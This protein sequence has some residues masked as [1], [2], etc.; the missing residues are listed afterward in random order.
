MS[1]VLVT[2]EKLDRLASIIAG[3][4][5]E[6]VKLTIDG[7]TG[8]AE[9]IKIEPNL[10][11]KSYTVDGAGTES[12]TADSGYDGLSEVEVNIRSGSITGPSS[13]YTS[14]SS[15][16]DTDGYGRLRVTCTD[17][18]TSP[19]VSS[20]GWV[21]SNSI[22][23][24][25]RTVKITTTISVNPT[26]TVSG[27]TVTIPEGYYSSQSTKSVSTM[28]LPTEASTSSYSGS[29]VANIN[30]ITS[31]QYLTIPEGYNGSACH[32]VI[33]AIQSGTQGTPTATKGVVSNHAITVTPSVTN[34][35]GYISGGTLTGTGVS[36]SASE[37]VGGTYTVSSSGTADVT[38]YASVSVP[39]ASVEAISMGDFVTQSGVLK[40]KLNAGAYAEG[41]GW[42]DEGAI[43]EDI[44]YFNAVPANTTI[45]PS[46]LSQTIGGENYMMEGAVTVSAMPSGT[47]G[48]PTA[49]KGT[50]SN[51]SVSVTPSVTNMT[52][53]ITG[54]TKTGTAVTVTAS[55][56]ASGNK[57]ITSNGTNIDVVG[58]STVSVSVSGGGGSSVQIGYSDAELD[59]ASSSIS[60]TGL[61][62]E[63][64]SFLIYI[65][66][67]LSTG[68]PARVA[69]VVFDGTNLHGQTLTNTSNANASY[70]TGFSKSYSNGTL[71][72]TAT[73]AQFQPEIYYILYSYGGTSACVDTKDVQVGSGATSITFTGIEDEPMYW[74]CIFK[75]NFGTSSGYQRVIFVTDNDGEVGMALD[76]SGHQ[77]TSWTASY[78][79]GSLTITST[80]TN[81]G[82]YFHQPG[83]YQL[84][85]AYDATGNY[86][87]KTVSPTTSQQVITA[88]SGYDALKK[89]TVNAMP[90]MTLPTATSA[91][92]SGTSKAT[93][94]PT[95]SVQYL[96]IPTGYNGTAQYYT[97]AAASG[98]GGSGSLTV[99]TASWQ[100]NSATTTS[101]QFTGLSGTPKVAFLRC[102][103]Q[104]TR[105]SQNTY[106]YI[107]D[108]FWDGTNCRGN[109]HLR[110]NGTFND[111]GTTGGFS[112]TTSSNS[113]TFSS[114]GSRSGAPGSFYNGTYELVYLY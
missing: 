92:S 97:I 85:Y 2:K 39:E 55:E 30:P 8:A 48:T 113:I 53:Y 25:F 57:E 62:G 35:E 108:I 17:V 20:T 66:G 32:Y 103:T 45:T 22:T 107:A 33:N 87:S 73:T 56:L 24:S 72:V 98:G 94:N 31:T 4:A 61:S 102:T 47:A 67:S 60:F 49:T 9:S 54:S 59:T 43:A 37:L 18:P 88:D 15:G 70:D 19:L 91:T 7:M 86:Q 63:P 111:V 16:L 23:S 42:V 26:I 6:K 69:A 38:N 109:Y 106:Y 12:I 95:S 10:Q 58:Y 101:H 80:G 104:L 14:N 100:N 105:S 3:K 44:T 82:G 5:G 40:W 96:N 65:N 36:V 81:N 64:T 93:I 52:G 41:A 83:Y 27:D 46:T 114:S 77:L 50:V 99:G 51:H 79:N 84:T 21:G 1:K 78:S 28:T 29:K 75:S 11:A 90:E 76:S 112:V 13:S 71:T 89:V 68:S 74:S 110:S 34:V